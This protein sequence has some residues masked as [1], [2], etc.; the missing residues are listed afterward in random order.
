MLPTTSRLIRSHP[1]GGGDAQQEESVGQDDPRSPG[2]E[3]ARLFGRWTFGRADRAGVVIPAVHGG[4]ELVE[5]DRDAVRLA[6]AGGFVDDLR[7]RRQLLEQLD[8]LRRRQR[9]QVE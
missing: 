1:V 7:E 3:Q 2:E 6:L 9:G 8:V 4:G 5:I